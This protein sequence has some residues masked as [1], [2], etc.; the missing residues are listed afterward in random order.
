[1]SG[2]GAAIGLILGAALTEVSWRLTLLI[3]LP[4]GLLIAFLAPRVLGE[5]ERQRGEFDLKVPS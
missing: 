5:S 3:N 1:M 4:I 2:A